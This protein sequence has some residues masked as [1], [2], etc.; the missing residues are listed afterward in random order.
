MVVQGVKNPL[1]D[2]LALDDKTL[3]EVF[4]LFVWFF[5]DLRA[6]A[7]QNQPLPFLAVFAPPRS[8]PFSAAGLWRLYTASLNVVV[9]Q[10]GKGEQ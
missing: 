9:N 2:L 8:L 10:N 3:D 6:W 5:F 7:S 1:V 4:F